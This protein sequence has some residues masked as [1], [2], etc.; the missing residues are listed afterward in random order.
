VK[1]KTRQYAKRQRTWFRGLPNVKVVELQ[2][3]ESARDLFDRLKSL[4][5]NSASR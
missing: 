2:P 1:I 3:K 4:C 5:L